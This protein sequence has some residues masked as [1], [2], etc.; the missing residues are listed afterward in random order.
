MFGD[1]F[2][3]YFNITDVFFF[4]CTL[5]R[6]QRIPIEIQHIPQQLCSHSIRLPSPIPSHS[7]SMFPVSHPAKPLKSLK[8]STCQLDPPPRSY[9]S[10]SKRHHSVLTYSFP[11]NFLNVPVA[12]LLLTYLSHNGLDQPLQSGFSPHHNAETA[13]ITTANHFFTALNS[14]S[15]SSWP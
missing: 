8:S 11:G 9:S 3:I 14:S 2:H 10:L 1:I 6:W 13:P 4:T 7:I 12:S 5:A 15:V